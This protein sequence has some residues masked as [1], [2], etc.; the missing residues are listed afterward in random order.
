MVTNKMNERKNNGHFQHHV[1][2]DGFKDK[3]RLFRF[4]ELIGIVTVA[5]TSLPFQQ[6]VNEFGRHFLAG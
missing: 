1:H 4:Y 6:R 5:E 3:S 2:I